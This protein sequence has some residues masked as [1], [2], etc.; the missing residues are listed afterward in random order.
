MFNLLFEVLE[1]TSNTDKVISFKDSFA[2][3]QN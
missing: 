1:T 2:A 3:K